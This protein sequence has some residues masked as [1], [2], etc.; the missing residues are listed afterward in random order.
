M[1]ENSEVGTFVGLAG[2]HDTDGGSLTHTVGGTHAAQFN[3]D[4]KMD[5]STGEITVKSGATIDYE[6]FNAHSIAVSV[7]DGKDA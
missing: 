3:E 1:D 6:T 5:V 2:A 7:T 4:F